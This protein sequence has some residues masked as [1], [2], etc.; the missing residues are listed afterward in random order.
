LHIS[1]Y[2]YSVG[3]KAKMLPLQVNLLTYSSATAYIVIVIVALAEELSTSLM[4]LAAL[5]SGRLVSATEAVVSEIP[6]R[7]KPISMTASTSKMLSL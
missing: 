3:Q 7:D 2:C 5:L 1:L 4:L 6:N